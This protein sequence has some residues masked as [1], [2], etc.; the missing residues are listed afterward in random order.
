MLLRE[1]LLVAA[2]AL[3]CPQSPGV[4][5]GG[6]QA[7]S[8]SPQTPRSTAQSFSTCWSLCSPS[9]W[10]LQNLKLD[11]EASSVP[12]AS[13]PPSS[14]QWIPGLLQSTPHPLPV[15]KRQCPG[16]Q[17]PTDAGPPFREGGRVSVFF[18]TPVHMDSPEPWPWKDPAPGSHEHGTGGPGAFEEDLPSPP[19]CTDTC[20]MTSDPPSALRPPHCPAPRETSAETPGGSP[21]GGLIMGPNTCSLQGL[22]RVWEQTGS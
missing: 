7:A 2:R 17:E 5:S 20:A 1:R 9:S 6:V 8:S 13:P 14:R 18:L 11:G 22:A 19:H 16:D 4:G 15:N 21:R 10:P 3:A 12:R